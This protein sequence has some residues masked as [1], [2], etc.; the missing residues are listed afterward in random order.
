MKRVIL[1]LLTLVTALTAGAQTRLTFDGALARAM[2]VNNVV[3]RML[4]EKSEA[5][6]PGSGCSPAGPRSR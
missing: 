5:R 3:E 1:A 4:S 6:A 2:V